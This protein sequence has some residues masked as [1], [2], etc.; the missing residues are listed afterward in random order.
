MACKSSCKLCKRLIISEDVIFTAGTGLIIDIPA[1]SYADGEK[2]CIV[3]AQ[4]IPAETT[5]TAPVFISIGGDVTTLYP[6]NNP[7]CTQ[8]TACGIKTRT[9]YA[10]VVRTTTA[11]GSFNLL[12]RIFCYPSANLPALPVPTP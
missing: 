8:V 11:G 2:Y 10:T 1:G 4:T 9:R 3:V 7:C 5:I 6:L 12:G